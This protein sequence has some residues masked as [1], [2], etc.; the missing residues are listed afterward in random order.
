MSSPEQAGGCD[1][2]VEPVEPALPPRPP[3]SWRRRSLGVAAA[4]LTTRRQCANGPAPMDT[5]S[6]IEVESP[7]TSWKPSPPAHRT[8]QL[9]TPESTMLR[10]PPLRASTDAR[11]RMA[12]LFHDVR[13]PVGAGRGL[14][15]SLHRL[16]D[17][18]AFA[19]AGRT[20]R[21]SGRRGGIRDDD[22]LSLRSAMIMERGSAV[23]RPATIIA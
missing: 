16:P 7:V 3:M 11:E 10:V 14:P 20:E 13:A 19:I 4:V 23:L 5:R 21:C 17:K 18:S 22:V 8:R 12:A 15:A 6:A 1:R 9:Q 2:V